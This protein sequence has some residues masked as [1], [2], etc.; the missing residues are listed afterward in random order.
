[1]RNIPFVILVG[2]ASLLAIGCKKTNKLTPNING[3]WRL[4][5]I[6]LLDGT[7][8]TDKF[9]YDNQG[10]LFSGRYL[11]LKFQD[12]ARL[13][14]SYGGGAPMGHG[15]YTTEDNGNMTVRNL[16]RGDESM[17]QSQWFSVSID[18]LNMAET[19]QE[20]DGRM[21]IYFEGNTK[22]IHL[23]RL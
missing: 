7:G 5:S 13:F 6:S 15:T 19:Y 2:F 22:K 8:A 21:F 20:I 23:T 17:F 4:D 11:I 14:L 10:Q 16:E 3:E 12:E 1:M 9:D 18:A